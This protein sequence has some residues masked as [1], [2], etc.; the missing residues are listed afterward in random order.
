MK[1][2]TRRA[3]PS[4]R[5]TT[6]TLPSASLDQAERIARARNVNVSTV[7]AEA[8]DASLR[9]HAATQRAEEVLE[10]YRQAFSGFTEEEL[11]VLDG[12]IPEGWTK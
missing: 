11:A 9:E 1:H 7:I 8:L 6:V 10:A 12:I 3:V 2:K 5:R 4:K